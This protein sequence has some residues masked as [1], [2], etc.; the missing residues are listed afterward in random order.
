MVEFEHNQSDIS[1]MRIW[2]WVG[3]SW[4]WELFVLRFWNRRKRERGGWIMLETV[5]EVGIVGFGCFVGCV[6]GAF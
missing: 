5:E 6:L 1:G 4:F 2:D 3:R